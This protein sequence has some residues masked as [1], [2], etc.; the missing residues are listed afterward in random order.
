MR[1]D[2]EFP[3]RDFLPEKNSK[4]VVCEPAREIPVLTECDVAVFGGGPAGVC[5]AAA[6]ARAGKRV[7]LVE[8]NGFLGGVATAA[9]VTILHSLYGTD[10]TTKVIGGL[11]EEI[12]RRLQRAGGVY[13]SEKNGETGHWVICTETAK[14]VLDDLVIGSGAKVLFQTQLAGV[15]CEGRRITAALIEGKSG[16]QA[17]IAN[18]YIDCTGDADLVR[19]AGVPTQLGNASGGCQAPSLCFR[20]RGKGPNAMPLGKVQA[21][22]FKTPMDYN[23]ER[24]PTLLWGSDGVRDK[25]EVMM[26]GVR[27]LNVNAADSLDLS[28]AEVEGRY[29]LRWILSRLKTMP[30]WENAYLTDV[31]TQIGIRESHRILADHQLAREEVLYGKTV[32]DVIAQGTYPIDIHRPDGPGIVF[33]NLDG[34][35]RHIAGDRTVTAGRWDGQPEGAPPR[36]T[37]C[38]QVPS[39]SLVPRDL[40]NVL[41][42]GRCIGATHESAGAIRVMI[43]CMQFGHAAGAAAA[44]TPAGGCARNVNAKALQERLI[45]DGAPLRIPKG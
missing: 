36:K 45:E 21:E 6:A 19:R 17:V 7:V 30:G 24:Y 9:N 10:K 29:Q 15:V 34:T 42:A 43:N 2:V 13:N 12:I 39:R 22:L 32:D 28:R 8:K 14:F 4:R 20:V 26:A 40:D 38:S 18:T 35:T 16:R 37:L 5:A 33:E 41:A 11:P 44:M 23:G 25:S 3:L 31:A 27:V 1:F